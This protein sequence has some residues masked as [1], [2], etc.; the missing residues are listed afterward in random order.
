[1]FS[2]YGLG[3]RVW[4]QKRTGMFAVDRPRLDSCLPI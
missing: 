4:S 2:D 3:F 1:M